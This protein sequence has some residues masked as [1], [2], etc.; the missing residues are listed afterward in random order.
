MHIE[1]LDMPTVSTQYLQLIGEKL[2]AYNVSSRDTTATLKIRTV[3]NGP[4]IT[5]PPGSSYTEENFDSA[6]AFSLY[7]ESDKPSNVGEIIIWE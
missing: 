5:V 1:N 4:Y 6:G 2:V 7:V 3:Q